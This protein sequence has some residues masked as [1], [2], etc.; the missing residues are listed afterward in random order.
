MPYLIKREFR[1]QTSRATLRASVRR[2]AESDETGTVAPE[3]R[4]T[5][6]N[7]MKSGLRAESA[8]ESR[9]TPDRY[10]PLPLPVLTHGSYLI[11]L[12][13]RDYRNSLL[14][15]RADRP[16]E[17]L[18]PPPYGSVRGRV[19][20]RKALAHARPTRTATPA[21]YV[22]TPPVTSATDRFDQRHRKLTT[23][24]AK[25][26]TRLQRDP[27]SVRKCE[28]LRLS[29]DEVKQN[30]FFVVEELE[31]I[32]TY[33]RREKVKAAAPPWRCV[34][35]KLLVLISTILSPCS[36]IAALSA[37]QPR[38]SPTLPY[39]NSVRH[40]GSTCQSGHLDAR[41]LMRA[42]FSTRRR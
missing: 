37:I 27:T 31:G 7:S 24:G 30:R 32:R 11:M 33:E 12:P 22:P 15:D 41:H 4:E 19:T 36:H 21:W 29:I 38:Y 3:G 18:P 40:S 6:R 25:V 5:M 17:E 8:R 23:R 16:P 26:I 28:A 39:S 2:D 13:D 20:P 34:T 10:A 35:H 14:L 42:L 1:P 9:R